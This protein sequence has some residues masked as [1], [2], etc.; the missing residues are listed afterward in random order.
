MRE[1]FAL[2]Q[3]RSA[4]PFVRTTGGFGR[5]P[6]ATRGPTTERDDGRRVGAASFPLAPALATAA[7]TVGYSDWLSERRERD[8]GRAPDAG[9]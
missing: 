2:E 6:A 4:E 9:V 8:G 5:K 7:V 1:Q 3:Y